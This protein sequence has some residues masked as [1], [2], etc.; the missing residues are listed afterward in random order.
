MLVLGET[1]EFYPSYQLKEVLMKITSNHESF[2]ESEELMAIVDSSDVIGTDLVDTVIT[3]KM[4][5][6][7]FD[8]GDYLIRVFGRLRNN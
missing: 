2:L 4:S 3:N 5:I 1:F 7:G 8:I 6:N